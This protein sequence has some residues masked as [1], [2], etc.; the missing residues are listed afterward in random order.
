[1]HHNAPS[2]YS[3]N[4]NYTDNQKQEDTKTSGLQQKKPL[5]H[6]FTGE[7]HSR[8]LTI[9]KRKSLH[10]VVYCITDN[11]ICTSHI[12]A[13]STL[14]QQPI[15][16]GR[17]RVIFRKPEHATTPAAYTLNLN[18]SQ[19]ELLC[20][21]EKYAHV[22]MKE[23]QHQ[24]KKKEIKANRQ[25]AT[26]HITKCLLCSENK[27]KQRSH[28]QQRGSITQNDSHPGSNTSIDHVDAANVPGYT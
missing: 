3:D 19:Q 14:A 8:V 28:K 12:Q 7:I 27:G 24:K 21:H 10:F 25:V 2:A 22:D 6:Y 11:N 1:M 23:I 9:L 4:K 15:N 16:K 17:E 20:L 26:C 5:Q 13:A 18:T